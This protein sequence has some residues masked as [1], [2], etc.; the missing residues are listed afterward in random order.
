MKKILL[1]VIQAAV[2]VGLLIWVFH[3]PTQRAQMAKALR[4]AEL[5]L[6]RGRRVRLCRCRNSSRSALAASCS[7]AKH[8]PFSPRLAVCF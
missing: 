6:G 1:T 5:S 7:R 2:T 4:L 8:S 3:D